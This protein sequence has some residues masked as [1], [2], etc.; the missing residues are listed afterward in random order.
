MRAT[1]CICLSIILPKLP[2]KMLILLL[3]INRNTTV[4]VQWGVP[5]QQHKC[6]MTMYIHV[7]NL[8]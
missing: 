3:I 6:I 8:L 5:I 2:D 4:I 1:R 7:V